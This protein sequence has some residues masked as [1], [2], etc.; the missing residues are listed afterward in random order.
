MQ[1]G[2]NRRDFITLLGGA[3]A[4]WP[5]AARAQPP[6]M[7]VIGFIRSTTAADAENLVIAFRRGLREAGFIEGQNVVVEYRWGENQA[8]RLPALVADLIRRPLAVIVGNITAAQ[9]AKAATTTVPIVFAIGSDPVRAG[10]VANLNRP[11]SNVTGVVFFGA[12]LGAKRLEQLRQFVPRRRRLP[13][14]RIPTLLVPRRSEKRC[15]PRRKR[16]GSHSS[17]SMSRTSAKSKQHLR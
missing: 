3:A 8:D 14:S 9:A 13:C 10:L 6:P 1:F 15:R 5:L 16:S 17:L 4:A 2:Q 7:P 11:G 12:D